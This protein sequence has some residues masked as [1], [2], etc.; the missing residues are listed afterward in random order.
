MRLVGWKSAGRKL[1]RPVLLRGSRS[2]AGVNTLGQSPLDHRYLRP[3]TF[4]AVEGFVS[5][6]SQHYRC[7]D[8]IMATNA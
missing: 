7:K 8:E 5:R 2:W 1:S 3:G 4:C 6:S